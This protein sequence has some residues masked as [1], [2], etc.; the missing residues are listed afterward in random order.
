MLTPESERPVES[1]VR[2]V[3]EVMGPLDTRETAAVTAA[4]AQCLAD[5]NRT[6]PDASAA[7]YPEDLALFA[8]Y[9]AATLAPPRG[10]LA[11]TLGLKGDE[12]AAFCARVR[13]AAETVADEQ[14][15]RSVL[16]RFEALDAAPPHPDR[17]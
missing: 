7:V 9:N 14:G 5:L 1:Q 3:L 12:A 13:A 17:A 16:H 11:I 10:F 4:V 6:L 15:R 8:A 2:A